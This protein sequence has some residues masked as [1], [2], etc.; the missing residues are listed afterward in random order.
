[1]SRDINAHYGFV[2][3]PNE[4]ETVRITAISRVI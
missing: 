4:S 1:M 3:N 2:P